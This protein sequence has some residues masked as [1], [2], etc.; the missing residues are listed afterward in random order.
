MEDSEFIARVQERMRE[1]EENYAI[2][3]EGNQ[4]AIWFGTE[5]LGLKEQDVAETY[6]IGGGG[7]DKIDLG[8]IADDRDLKI[9]VQC[10]YHAVPTSFNKDL[11]DQ[12]RNARDRIES[13]PDSGNTKRKEFVKKFRI[14]KK[15]EKLIAVGFGNTT[16][17][18]YR[19][20]IQHGVEVY[21]FEKLKR[22]YVSFINPGEAPKPS[23]ATLRINSEHYIPYNEDNVKAHVFLLKVG[24][25]FKA[26]SN[27]GVGLF[28][29]NLRLKL[30]GKRATEIFEAIKNTVRERPTETV[31]LNNGITFV[32]DQTILDKENGILKLVSPQIVNGCQ[33]S[34]AVFE[35]LE[36][37][38]KGEEN[39]EGINAYVLTKVIE[40]T[41][42]VERITEATNKQ[43]PIFPKDLRAKEQIHK[44]IQAKFAEFIPSKS[45]F[46]ERREGDW[47]S[48]TERNQQG[49]FRIR[50]QRFRR[51]DKELGGQLY[52]SLMGRPDEAK[53]Q[54]DLMWNN[55]NYHKAIFDYHSND[56]SVISIAGAEHKLRAGLDE[57][58]EDMFFAF[59]IYKLANAITSRCYRDK[60]KLYLPDNEDHD[61][62]KMLLKYYEFL[63]YWEFHLVRLVHFIVEWKS[64]ENEERR[65]ELRKNLIGPLSNIDIFFEGPKKI[66]EKF[67]VERDLNRR[68]ILDHNNPSDEFRVFGKWF[69]RLEFL[70]YEIVRR[71][72]DR[73]D[74]KN[75]NYFFYKKLETLAKI[76]VEVKN[77][78]AGIDSDKYFPF[79]RP[80]T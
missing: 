45:I 73:D 10:K 46:Y 43:N 53:N 5:V 72:M 3:E 16:P 55:D 25:L 68:A 19:Y 28:E 11:V 26:V 20:A 22:S 7:D 39:V 78:L 29:E 32:C 52:W 9:I 40:S 41:E 50:G 31:I 58:V 44:D 54:T 4:F 12:V 51:L 56:F 75:M 34:Y 48:V 76:T 33:T 2:H 37:L 62:Y 59:A 8:V 30:K 71:A 36:E 47:M 13:S 67:N 18:V 64:G 69:S 27:A 65:R 14:S 38:D 57:R 35:V 60:K 49:Q 24:E 15:P 70:T 79:Q 61:V 63:K 80:E 6:H 74:W 21:D 23:M 1:I 17:D 42:D 77:D 66:A